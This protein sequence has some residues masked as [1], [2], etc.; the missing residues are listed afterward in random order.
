MTKSEILEKI[1]KGL[2]GQG[3]QVDIGNV[4]ADILTEIADGGPTLTITKTSS[5]TD[6]TKE[7]FATNLGITET[8]VDNLFR[9]DYKTVR[10]KIEGGFIV[11]PLVLAYFLDD[12]TYLLFG[13]SEGD[14]IGASLYVACHKDSELYD[15]NFTEM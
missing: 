2:R 3:N 15:I 12:N 11:M 4:L 10:K 8:E 6:F 5:D 9:G 13:I 7:E 1:D 14:N